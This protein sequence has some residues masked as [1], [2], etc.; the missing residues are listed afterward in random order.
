MYNINRERLINTFTDLVRLSSPSWEEE[1]V[2]LY[3]TKKLKQLNV[4]FNKYKCGESHNVLAK[5]RGNSGKRPI[6][7]S[8]HMDTVVPCDNVKPVV[9]SSKIS[10]DGTS[11]LGADDKAAMAAFLEAVQVLKDEKMEHGTVEILFTCAEE[12]GLYGIKGFDTSLLESEH[13]FVFDSD[14]EIGKVIIEA[15]YHSTLDISIKG[16]A[17]HAGMEPEKGLNAILVISEI[18]TKIPHGRI[19]EETTVN[20]GVISGGKATNIVAENATCKLEVRSLSHRKLLK[21]EKKI[22]DIIVDVANEQGARARLSRNLEYSGFSIKQDQEIVHIVDRA[23]R[24]IN[25]KPKYLSSGGGSD[26]NILNEN[27]IKAIN[28]SVGMRNV[29]TKKECIMIKDLVNGA[30]LALSII[31]SV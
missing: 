24:K 28:L 1:E 19:D 10:S 4:K 9:T 22:K 26:T 15:P 31:D 12:V 5:L 23:I 18:I 29:H 3:L 21:M 16:K 17:A 2:I 14:G 27:G 20:V 13:A 8:C 7:L 11:I 6:L 30:K 25:L